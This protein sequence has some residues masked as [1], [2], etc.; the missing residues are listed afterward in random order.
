MK[1][2]MKDLTSIGLEQMLIFL[3]ETALPRFTK[4]KVLGV[5]IQ[6]SAS[7]YNL[8]I[9]NK[10]KRLN[11]VFYRPNNCT[12][13]GVYEGDCL[14]PDLTPDTPI[15][16]KSYH[17]SCWESDGVERVI[18]G[19]A[20]KLNEEIA[21]EEGWSVYN[22]LGILP[23]AKFFDGRIDTSGDIDTPKHFVKSED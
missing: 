18:W 7:H 3:V 10:F 23:H 4:D 19:V 21:G 15:T 17:D 20:S 22:S 13:V 8:D 5:S 9:S 6:F 14:F 12:F 11:F 2:Y 16:Q 1:N